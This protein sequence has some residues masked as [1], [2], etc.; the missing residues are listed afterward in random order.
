M[1]LLFPSFQIYLTLNDEKAKGQGKKKKTE[2]SIREG[3]NRGS[4]SDTN[5]EDY[6][7]SQ[8]EVRQY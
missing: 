8:L 4:S 1:T 5:D 3:D 2:I 7:R 6:I